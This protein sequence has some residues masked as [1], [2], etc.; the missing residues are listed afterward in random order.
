MYIRRK[1]TPPKGAPRYYTNNPDR[2][3]R[4]I[5]RGFRNVCKV[6]EVIIDLTLRGWIIGTDNLCMNDFMKIYNNLR[7]MAK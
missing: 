5:T 7:L 2:M 6:D 1:T 3:G 4:M